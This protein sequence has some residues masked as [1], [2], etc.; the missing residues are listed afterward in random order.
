[1]TEMRVMKEEEWGRGWGEKI[2]MVQW[3][4]F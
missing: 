2:W 1:M 4:M 3:D